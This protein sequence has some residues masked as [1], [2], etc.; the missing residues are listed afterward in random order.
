MYCYFG[1]IIRITCT[2]K[3]ALEHFAL[4]L[5]V[6]RAPSRLPVCPNNCLYSSPLL[7]FSKSLVA[8]ICVFQDKAT[9]VAASGC[10]LLFESWLQ[11]LKSEA[12][13]LGPCF[14]LDQLVAR[15]PFRLDR[16]VPP[17]LVSTPCSITAK[18]NQVKLKLAKPYY[19]VSIQMG[20]FLLHTTSNTCAN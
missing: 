10:C 9:V 17:E 14:G 8:S 1:C 4:K 19:Y 2:L 5:T 6:P 7:F 3:T 16:N 15:L 18:Q 13:F 20:S 11:S 12:C